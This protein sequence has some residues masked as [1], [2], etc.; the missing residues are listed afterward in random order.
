M[1]IFADEHRFLKNEAVRLDRLSSGLSL[2]AKRRLI[3]AVFS[4][5]SDPF[6]ALIELKFVFVLSTGEI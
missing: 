2:K 3:N 1:I 5:E 4:A 6:F